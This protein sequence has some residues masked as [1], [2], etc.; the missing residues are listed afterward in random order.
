M[1]LAQLRMKLS[2][3][4]TANSGW[5]KPLKHKMIDQDFCHGLVNIWKEEGKIYLGDGKKANYVGK[6]HYFICNVFLCEFP[7]LVN[8]KLH[9]T[10]N[11]V[12]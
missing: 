1:P 8:T 4:G 5:R 10:G 12:L 6:Y 3:T 9:F 11:N 2:N 7:C